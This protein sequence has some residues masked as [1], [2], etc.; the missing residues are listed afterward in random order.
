[1]SI[2][3]AKQDAHLRGFFFCNLFMELP[4]CTRKLYLRKGGIASKIGKLSRFSAIWFNK[5]RKKRVF[6]WRFPPFSSVFKH[7]IGQKTYPFD[8]EG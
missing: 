3:V 1:M 4:K 6:L 7:F 8:F 2:M 5:I